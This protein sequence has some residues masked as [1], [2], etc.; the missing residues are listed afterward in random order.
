MSPVS[1]TRLVR[2]LRSNTA[3]KCRVTL[4]LKDFVVCS[5]LWC[6][7]HAST[8]AACQL[9]SFTQTVQSC[10]SRGNREHIFPYLPNFV[11]II[12]KF[13]LNKGGDK[14]WYISHISMIHI[15]STHW[16]KVDL[17]SR[18]VCVALSCE[19]VFRHSGA[20]TPK[21]PWWQSVNDAQESYLYQMCQCAN[22]SS[23]WTKETDWKH[24]TMALLKH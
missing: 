14:V 9:L 16:N 18:E 19:A 15:W 7:L 5:S 22:L 3:C 10:S 13:L 20:L 23:F 2:S 6:W 24:G 4:L 8:L 11:S 21:L 1:G 17:Q 12:M